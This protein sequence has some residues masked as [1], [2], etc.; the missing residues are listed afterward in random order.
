MSVRLSVCLSVRLSVTLWYCIKTNKASVIHGFFSDEERE[1]SSFS[2]YPVH[3]EIQ[4]GSLRA[5]A[6][7]ETGVGYKLARR[8]MSWRVL[9]FRQNCSEVCRTKHN[10]VS[11]KNVAGTLTVWWYTFLGLTAIQK[12]SLIRGASNRTSVFTA[13]AHAV[14]RSLM[15]RIY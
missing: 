15:S 9:A 3:P 1:D 6:I 8:L 12:G 10:T 7:Y 14:R 4:K 11:S 5:R 13:L 2:K